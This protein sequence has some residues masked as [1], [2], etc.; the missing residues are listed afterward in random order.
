MYFC[1]DLGGTNCKIAVFDREG[2]IIKF[3]K[4]PS[5]SFYNPENFISAFKSEILRFD[6]F[7][8]ISAISIG[9]PGLINSDG[10]VITSPNF[11]EWKEFRVKEILSYEFNCPV[12]VENDANLFALGEGFAGSAKDYIS[13]VGITIG[14]GIGGGIVLDGRL[15][16]GVKSMAGEIGHMVI[17][18]GGQECSCG[19]K[20]CLEAYSSGLAI[21]RQMLQLTGLELEAKEIYALAKK[22]D[23]KAQKVFEKSAYNLGIGIANLANILDVSCFIIGGGISSAFDIMEDSIKKGFREHTFKVHYDSVKI[24]QSQLK[25]QS[26]LYGAFSIIER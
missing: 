6:E 23:K 10:V 18:P 25:D 20:G 5:K 24:V 14:T 3:W 21:K 13:Y 11:P 9:M 17:H 16:K 2:N 26:A 4:S 8:F 12:Y 19:N 22:G 15:L 7:K 1:L